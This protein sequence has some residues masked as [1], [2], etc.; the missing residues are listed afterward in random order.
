M[1]TKT[2]K[3]KYEFTKL[4]DTEKAEL[5]KFIME[6]Q[7]STNLQKANLNESLRKSL[8]PTDAAKCGC[9]GK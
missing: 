3:L 8:G 7:T 6:Y 2:E 9:C 4:L 1:S 5:T